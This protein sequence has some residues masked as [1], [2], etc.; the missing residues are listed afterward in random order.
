MRRDEPATMMHLIRPLLLLLGVLALLLVTEQAAGDSV[1][2]IDV[3]GSDGPD[4]LLSH[5]AEL[6]GD[7]AAKYAG[8]VVGRFDEGATKIEIDAQAILT[9]M[10]D[11][12]AKLGLLDL[13]GFG[14]C[15]VHRTYNTVQRAKAS[16]SEPPA[17][18]I[19]RQGGGAVTL[20]SPTTVRSLI[21]QHIAKETGLGLSNLQITF[22]DRDASLLGQSAVAGRYEIEPMSA[23][24]LGRAT[25]KVQGYVGTQRQG[26]AKNLSV[27]IKQRV[28]AVVAT[29][30]IDRGEMIT[31]R[32][33]RLSE[34]LIDDI[35]Q[36]YLSQTSMVTGQVASGT[37]MPGTLIT[38]S[39]VRLPTAVKRRGQVAVE[40]KTSGVKITFNAIA[41]EEG[42]VGDTI[43]VLNPLTKERFVATVAGR[44]KVI[45]GKKIQNEEGSDR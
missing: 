18:N 5:V 13:M 26:G 35:G 41:Q 10:R 43:E 21:E 31:R 15:T 44:G 8:V 29:D 24:M 28:I 2:I 4:I 14:K 39:E 33:V 9:A 40:L 36:P 1:R 6:E 42:A 22:S 38:S 27:D 19:D 16:V 34:V 17:T 37:I 3:A 45:A 32:Q 11:E 7:Y 12:G 23:V 30:R 20:D 25:F